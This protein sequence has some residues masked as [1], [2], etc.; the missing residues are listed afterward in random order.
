MTPVSPDDFDP[1]RDWP[2]RAKKLVNEGDPGAERVE[3]YA[4]PASEYVPIAKLFRF[5]VPESVAREWWVRGK[6]EEWL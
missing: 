2:C 4:E 6:K 3:C 1:E 5:N